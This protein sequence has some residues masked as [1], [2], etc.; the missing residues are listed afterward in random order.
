MAYA[1][2]QHAGGAV[3]TTLSASI[4]SGSVSL[5]LAQSNAWPDGVT[6]PFYLVI[7]PGLANEEKILATTRT[8]LTLNSLTRGVDGTS[9]AAHASGAVII[10]CFTATEADEANVVAHQTLG[11]VTAKGDLLVASGNQTLGKLTAGANDT[12][13]IYDST[14]ATGLKAGQITANQIVA[15][16]ITP[17]QLAANS[18]TNAKIAPGAVGTTSLADGAVTSAKIADG[19]IA[20]VDLADGLIT[21][22]KLAAA[23]AV[24][25]GLFHAAGWS[26]TT[27]GSGNATIPHGAGFTP[28]ICDITPILPH[29]AVPFLVSLDAT[30]IVL[31]YTAIT[32]SVAGISIS[33]HFVVFP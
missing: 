15:G 22:A 14:Q 23:P 28:S 11:Q 33:G 12:V 7:D 26:G 8:A 30:N 20:T 5:G 1:R 29:T 2:I 16:T 21:A 25:A 24:S 3:P 6:G 18:V 17:T 9:A 19:T 13:P 32:G 10:H 27:D 4:T 31:K